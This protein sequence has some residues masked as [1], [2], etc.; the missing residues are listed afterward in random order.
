M[1][2]IEA[3]VEIARRRA[4]T[5]WA[6]EHPAEARARVKAIVQSAINKVRKESKR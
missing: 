4:L 2:R 5:E 1:T 6:K 3:A